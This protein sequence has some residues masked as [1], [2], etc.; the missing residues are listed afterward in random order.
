MNS[1]LAPHK[2]TSTVAG[3]VLAVVLTVMLTVAFALAG[4]PGSA[5]AG[6]N[7]HHPANKVA[8]AD[9]SIEEHAP[10]TDVTLM[11]TTMR[12]A[13]SKGLVFQVTL[14]CSILTDLV[15]EGNDTARAES[16]LEV[17]VEVDGERVAVGDSSDDGHTGGTVTFCNREYQRQTRLWEDEEAV[18]DDHIDTKQAHGFNWFDSAPGGGVKN[19]EVKANLD[20]DTAGS[21]N[22]TLTVGNRT[23]VVEPVDVPR[24]GGN[25]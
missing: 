23:L 13:A 14:E 12:N 2:T 11:E 7:D 8:L 25:R 3:L 10:G 15:T 1:V 22:A 16:T 4:G 18:I 20:T 17:W 24:G 6:S 19:I 9:S 21:A 5:D